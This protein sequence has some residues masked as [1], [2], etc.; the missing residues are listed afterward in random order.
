MLILK[1]EKQGMHLENNGRHLMMDMLQ[2]NKNWVREGSVKLK[3]Q[4]VKLIDLKLIKK[5]GKKR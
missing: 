1:K 3:L 4:S 5:Q 2:S